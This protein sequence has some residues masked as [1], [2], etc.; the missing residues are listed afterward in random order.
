MKWSDTFD[1]AIALSEAHPDV[2][3]KT[4]RFT[5]LIAWI[6]ALDEFDDNVDKCNEKVLEA[7]QMAWI[8]EIS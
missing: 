3:P 1:I 4:I 7:V 5:D 2:D 6:Q 8:E